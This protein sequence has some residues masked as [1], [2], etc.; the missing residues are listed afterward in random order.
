VKD[1]Y[2]ANE[3]LTMTDRAKIVPVVSVTA[4]TTGGMPR[5]VALQTLLGSVGAGLALPS[6]VSAQHP[7]HTHLAS[8]SAIEN[9]HQRASGSGPTPEFLDP[10]QAKTLDALAEAIVPGSI[11]ARVAAFLDGLLAVESPAN[12]RAFLG[13]LGAF[14]MAAIKQHRKAWFAITPADQDAILRDASTADVTSAM[15]A[16]FENL[17]GWIA[18][19]YY[20]SEAGMRELG[21]TGNVFHPELPGCTHPGGHQE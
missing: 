5:R 20:S 10:H 18:G 21:W 12:Q 2:A 7:I 15:R 13:A 9:A 8:P 6:A 14:D 3:A 19:A 16:H 17:K 4:P 1:H 11:A